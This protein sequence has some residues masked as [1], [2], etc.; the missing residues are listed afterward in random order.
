MTE[1]SMPFADLLAKR[2]RGFPAQRR[3][4]CAPA[5]DG[6]RRGW[7][8]RGETVRAQRQRLTSRNG[9]RERTRGKGREQHACGSCYQFLQ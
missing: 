1:D 9:V 2:R 7:P 8:D 5:S 4:N 6:G 3:R